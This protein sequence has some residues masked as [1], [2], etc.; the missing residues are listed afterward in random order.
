LGNP[1]RCSRPVASH[2]RS[3]S[4]MSTWLRRK[5]AKPLAESRPLV[6]SYLD[7]EQK[8]ARREASRDPVRQLDTRELARPSAVQGAELH[9]VAPAE[10]R[11]QADEDAPPPSVA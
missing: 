4:C 5:P 6:H 1:R 9:A 8:P 7:V 3:L 11:G 2:V 10:P